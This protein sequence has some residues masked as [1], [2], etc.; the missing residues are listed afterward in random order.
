MLKL[1]RHPDWERRLVAAEERHQ[2]EPFAW[3]VCD[4]ILTAADAIEAVTGKDPA[5]R[6]RGIYSTEIGAAKLLRRRKAGT[7][8]DVLAKLL[9]P[10]DGVLMAQR[11]DIC[12]VERE[13]QIAAGY[14]TMHGIA[15]KSPRG[16]GYVPITEARKAFKVG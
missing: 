5:K 1:K 14:V 3:G 2:A 16:L 8:E 4:C 11:G 12:T 15:V 7:V 13:G 6:V 10:A 9:P